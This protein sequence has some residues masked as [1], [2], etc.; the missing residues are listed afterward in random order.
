[1]PV[2]LLSQRDFELLVH[3]LLLTLPSKEETR[4]CHVDATVC[5]GFVTAFLFLCERRNGCCELLPTNRAPLRNRICGGRT[6]TE[7]V[8]KLIHR[9]LIALTGRS[10]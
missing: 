6:N 10:S 7:E 2:V 9:Y 5:E 1:M 8:A 3:T 4:D